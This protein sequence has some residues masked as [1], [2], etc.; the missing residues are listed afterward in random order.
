MQISL[1]KDFEKTFLKVLENYFQ[2]VKLQAPCFSLKREC[3]HIHTT[4]VSSV[5]SAYDQ[6][7]KTYL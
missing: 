7:N 3:K 6:I 4:Y 1:Y 5:K 2:D